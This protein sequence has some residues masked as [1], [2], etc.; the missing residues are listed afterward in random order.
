MA[1]PTY[2]LVVDG[3]LR[4][5]AT[6]AVIESGRA[7]YW[8]LVETGRLALL[9]GEDR[10]KVDWFLRTN[11]FNK[12]VH[13]IP[14]DPTS[15]PTPSGR[16]LQQIRELRRA[17]SNITFVVEPNPAIALD[18]YKES[19]PVMVYLH[20][21]YTQPA[22]RPG[23]KSVAKPWEDLISEVEFQIEQKAANAYD[24]ATVVD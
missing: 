15:S 13:L 21:V 11:A 12:H 16:R 1:A 17:Q 24:H 4:K 19:V 3:V 18:L 14:E 6:N 8:S 23:Y 22:F 2:V 10:D 7:L 20:P 9:C 5:P